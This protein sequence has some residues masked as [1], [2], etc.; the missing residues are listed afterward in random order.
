MIRQPPT[1]SLLAVYS[2]LPLVAPLH[3]SLVIKIFKSPIIRFDGARLIDL[4]TLE[5][6]A[7]MSFCMTVRFRCRIRTRCWNVCEKEPRNR[8]IG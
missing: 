2:S 8:T 4:A 7:A 1:H 6:R 5:S 3:S